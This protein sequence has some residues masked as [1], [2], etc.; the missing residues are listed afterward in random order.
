VFYGRSTLLDGFEDTWE[1]ESGDL[2]RLSQVGKRNEPKVP[3]T[4]G[5]RRSFFVSVTLKW[6][7][8]TGSNISKYCI[9]AQSLDFWK[10]QKEK[11]NR[12]KEKIKQ[13][14]LTG[15]AV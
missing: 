7:Y 3:L 15:E 9:D 8:I 6:N 11:E 1:R 5:S 10:A 12:K 14:N 2:K 13:K 4:A